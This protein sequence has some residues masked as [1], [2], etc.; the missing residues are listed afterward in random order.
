MLKASNR[1]SWPISLAQNRPF[2]EILSYLVI[3]VNKQTDW[4]DADD[5]EPGPIVVIC[6]VGFV[7]SQVG[8]LQ[9]KK[10]LIKC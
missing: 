4:C 1:T 7:L 2:D 10:S 9:T 6:C 3:E 8:W 5:D